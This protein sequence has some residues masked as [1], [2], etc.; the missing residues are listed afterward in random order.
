MAKEK[1]LSVIEQ[2]RKALRE[3]SAGKSGMPEELMFIPVDG[4]K[5]VRFLSEFDKPVQVVMHDKWGE[6]MPQPCFEYYGDEFGDCPYHGGN[7]RTSTQ[8]AYTVY[9]YEADTRRIFLQAATQ[10]SALDDLLIIWDDLETLTDRDMLITRVKAQK[11]SR[12]KAREHQRHATAFE[13]KENKPFPEEKIYT[14]LKGLINRE[15]DGNGDSDK[16][17]RPSRRGEED[18][19]TRSSRDEDVDRSSRRRGRDEDDDRDQRRG[20]GRDSEVHAS[21][22][23]ASRREEDPEDLLGGD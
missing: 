1:A 14:V 16:D 7:F 4:K 15:K 10:A 8:Y 11:G 13:G 12:Y 22:N 17:D 18:R 19:P 2:I 21:G 3:G 6:L 20:R 9:D 5:V 23:R